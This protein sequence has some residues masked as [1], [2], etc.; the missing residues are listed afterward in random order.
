MKT[1]AFVNDIGG[2]SSME[3]STSVQVLCLHAIFPS[4]HAKAR[5]SC[6]N[7]RMGSAFVPVRASVTLFSIYLFS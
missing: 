6:E 7:V 1:E 3:C 5:V 2:H 4:V